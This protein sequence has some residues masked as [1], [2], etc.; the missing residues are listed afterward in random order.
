MTSYLCLLPRCES[1]TDVDDVATDL[2]EI[3][4]GSL[5]EKQKLEKKDSGFHTMS[6]KNQN[7]QTVEEE[8]LR[9][10]DGAW[11]GGSPGSASDRLIRGPSVDS[12]I[13]S[14]V[15]ATSTRRQSHQDGSREE[16]R[17]LLD[18]NEDE[19]PDQ[20][21]ERSSPTVS[22]SHDAT[23]IELQP[24]ANP[25]SRATTSDPCANTTSG[26]AESSSSNG[27]KS[28]LTVPQKVRT[29]ILKRELSKIQRELKAL[30]EI[31]MEI[32]YV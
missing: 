32:S 3:D 21:Q 18:E 25:G 22:I 14:S 24:L 29:R 30:G 31:E 17:S 15:V 28:T 5:A 7:Y 12:A 13:E 4:N 9:R 27:A 2:P 23:V 10:G 11:G 19:P 20:W 8:A 6:F 1:L 26:G 16:R